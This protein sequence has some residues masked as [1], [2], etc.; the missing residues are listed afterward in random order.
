MKVVEVEQAVV[1]FKCPVC[2]SAWNR[3]VTIGVDDLSDVSAG[4]D[5]E[6][7]LGGCE[8]PIEATVVGSGSARRSS[9]P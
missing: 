2:G 1:E 3:R 9:V 7:H 5:A 4:E 8:S 6:H